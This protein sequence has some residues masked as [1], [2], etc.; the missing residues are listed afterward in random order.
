MIDQRFTYI[1]DLVSCFQNPC[2][3][4]PLFIIDKKFLREHTHFIYY[5]TLY[6]HGTTMRPIRWS[7]IIILSQVLFQA[8]HCGCPSGKDIDRIEPCVL[9]YIALGIKSYFRTGDAN[10]WVF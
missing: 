6:E 3:P 10:G 7:G 8:S 5:F 1:P 4:V 9:N 2:G